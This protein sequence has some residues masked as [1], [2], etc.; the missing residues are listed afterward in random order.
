MSDEIL[1]SVLSEETLSMLDKHGATIDKVDGILSKVDSILNKP[2]IGDIF[3]LLKDKAMGQ[4]EAAIDP[5]GMTIGEMT[6]AQQIAPQQIAQPQRT[7]TTPLEGTV[8]PE[9]P[10]SEIH[11][12]MHDSIDQMSEEQIMEMIENE[13]KSQSPDHQD[14]ECDPEDDSNTGTEGSGEEHPSGIDGE[15]SEE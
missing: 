11:Q 5:W 9:P 2:L 8:S 4:A 6:G 10:K 12:A 15:T 7:I 3:D 14:T 13:S 1:D